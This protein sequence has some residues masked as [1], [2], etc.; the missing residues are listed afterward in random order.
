MINYLIKTMNKVQIV[1]EL[2][3]I[4]DYALQS[5]NTYLYHRTQRILGSLQEIWSMEEFYLLEM[6]KNIMQ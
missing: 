2:Q 1:E 5:E 4:I 6:Q 3:G